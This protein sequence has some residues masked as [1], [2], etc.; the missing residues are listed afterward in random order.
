MD[1]LD[2]LLAESRP[3]V[4]PAATLAAVTAAVTRRRPRRGLVIAGIVTLS[5][6]GGTAAA[7]TTGPLG[8][9]I[10]SYLNGHPND[11]AW[12]MDIT[13]TD[14]TMHCIG[15]IVVL[16]ATEKPT[17]VEA[18]YLA[19][20]RFVE[21]HDWAGLEPDPS[22]LHDGQ[23]GTAEQLA[24]T[25]DRHMIEVAVQAGYTTDSIYT[26]GAAECSPR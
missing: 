20:K 19:I 26:Q 8:D 23:E 4:A 5:L 22:L 15:G 18:D 9:L 25:A 13:G 17:Y 21:Q 7:A 11:H 16:P 3:Q 1:R 6:A 12:E 2:E 14:G 10:D 24:I